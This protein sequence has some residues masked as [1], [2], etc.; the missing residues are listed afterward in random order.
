MLS[1]K[2]FIIF[3]SLSTYCRV[4]FESPVPEYLECKCS[5]WAK[6]RVFSMADPGKRMLGQLR[7]RLCLAKSVMNV[8][9]TNLSRSSN[10][11]RNFTSEFPRNF[12]VNSVRNFATHHLDKEQLQSRLLAVLGSFS[13]ATP[14]PSPLTA[15]FSSDLGLDSLDVVEVV[16]AV[17]EEFGL[18]IPDEVADGFSGMGDVCAYLEGKLIEKH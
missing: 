9:K 7:G 4:V 8:G 16:M 18:E 3:S 14:H 10:F 11:T 17:E 1:E 6:V 13:K 12:T 15:K 5:S 2:S